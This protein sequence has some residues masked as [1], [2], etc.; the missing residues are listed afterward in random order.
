MKFETPSSND[1]L[2]QL[3][4]SLLAFMLLEHTPVLQ[5]IIDYGKCL[6]IVLKK[7]DLLPELFGEVSSLDDLHVEVALTL[8]LLNSGVSGVGQRA[9]VSVA[10]T[11]KVVLVPAELLCFSRYLERAGLVVDD[12]PD[13]VVLDH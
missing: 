4:E 3:S 8:V 9:T 2:M 11:S 7:F 13:N 1:H 12:L 6:F 5:L 10:E